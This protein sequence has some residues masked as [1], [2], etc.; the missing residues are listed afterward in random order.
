MYLI[1]Y[2][3]LKKEKDTKD[4]NNLIKQTGD[5]LKDLFISR[6]SSGVVARFGRRH[7]KLP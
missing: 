4:R 6:W 2:C 3:F 5:F 1:K 7:W